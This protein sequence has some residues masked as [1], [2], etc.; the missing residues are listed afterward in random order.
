LFLDP[1]RLEQA[2]FS[3]SQ[4]RTSF[5]VSQATRS[6]DCLV[7]EIYDQLFKWVV[8]AVNT[9][10]GTISTKNTIGLLDVYGYDGFEGIFTES[11]SLEQ[12]FI[13]AANE[14][15]FKSFTSVAFY[16]EATSFNVK[17]N[18][19]TQNER[20]VDQ[21]MSLRNSSILSVLINVAA[22][23]EVPD[24]NFVQALD[25]FNLVQSVDYSGRPSFEYRHS[26][27]TGPAG[28]VYDATGFVKKN[29]NGVRTELAEV[30]KA[31]TNDMMKRMFQGMTVLKGGSVPVTAA[32]RFI[33]DVEG[34]ISRVEKTERHWIRC[35][36]PTDT[37][38]RG[39]F[40]PRQVWDQMDAQG[41]MH[42][43]EQRKA[44][45]SVCVRLIQA[46]TRHFFLYE[47]W[48]KRK[49]KL[50]RIQSHS[51]MHLYSKFD[52]GRIPSTLLANILRP[53]SVARDTVARDRYID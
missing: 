12:L 46:R 28:F 33:D 39:V 26:F 47:Q 36:S 41:D 8:S 18:T 17:P 2:L 42:A 14:R 50:E 20:R 27:K 49:P 31:S 52:L 5:T 37:Q 13:N 32:K 21:L 24:S 35:I 23:E 15:L 7:Q 3:D 51:R 9:A 6:L 38:Q 11:N 45:H 4:K 44:F 40:N 29:N 19:W 53:Y 25:K 10:T 43:M 16:G 1:A 22:A 48:M 30:G 34:I